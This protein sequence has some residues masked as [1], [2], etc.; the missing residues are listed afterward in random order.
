MKFEIKYQVNP[1]YKITQERVRELVTYDPDTGIFRYNV[2]RR[3]GVKAGDIA[4]NKAHAGHVKVKVDC[5]HI[6]ASR[7][8]WSMS[9]GHGP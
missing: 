9:T 1:T 8:A 4:G 6:L 5:N 3:N 7:L 2:D